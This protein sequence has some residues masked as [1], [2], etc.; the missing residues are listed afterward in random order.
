MKT[1]MS[2]ILQE[3]EFNRDG[4]VLQIGYGSGE[5]TEFLVER[6]QSVICLEPDRETALHARKCTKHIDKVSIVSASQLDIADRENFDFIFSFGTTE[7]LIGN[8][9]TDGNSWKDA[10]SKMAH[11]LKPDG[12]LIMAMQKGSMGYMEIKEHLA[13]NFSE[14]R[15]YY[16]F[17]D[18]C[19]PSLVLSGELFCKAEIGELVGG[20][21]P[22]DRRYGY[23]KWSDPSSEMTVQDDHELFHV[24]D[25][26]L[27]VAGKKTTSQVTADWLGIMF[28]NKRIPALQTVTKIYEDDAGSLR[29]QKSP[30]FC[31]GSVHAGKIILHPI[32]SAWI[33]GITLHHQ[34]LLSCRD[35]QASLGE[36]FSPCRVWIDKIRDLCIGESEN[37]WLEGRYIDNIWKNCIIVDS[38]CRFFDDEWE[39]VDRIPL[40]LFVIR[41]LVYFL[42]DVKGLNDKGS[43]FASKT[44]W[45]LC[46]DI[47]RGFGISL[48]KRDA[49]AFIRLES[50]LQKTVTGTPRIKT[51]IFLMH[52]L[53]S[54]TSKN[55]LLPGW[56]HNMICKRRAQGRR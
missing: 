7:Y 51:A 55:L 41:S 42:F 17:P 52:F 21:L 53:I 43:A 18:L 8:T 20:S 49:A 34:L 35:Q 40:R 44:M 10:V 26:I 38:H 9:G 25:D 24:A 54:K 45:G 47:A 56:F 32:D 36:I 14:V 31:S 15:W 5:L 27:L 11:M 13:Q 4:H 19:S 3:F 12:I 48:N 29:V 33:N 1:T 6:F 23:R 30:R 39:W 2:R 37:L 16:P 50:D 28:A 22:V 46:V